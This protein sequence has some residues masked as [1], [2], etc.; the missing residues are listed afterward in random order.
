MYNWKKW[1]TLLETDREKKRKMNAWRGKRERQ[2]GNINLTVTT[3]ESNL[4]EMQMK[5]RERN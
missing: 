3:L 4:I 5:E 1:V 2:S